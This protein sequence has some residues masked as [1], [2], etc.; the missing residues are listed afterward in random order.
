VETNLM[1][2]RRRD[3]WSKTLQE[4][5]SLHHDMRRPVAPRR[6]EPIGEPPVGHRLE[7][8]DCERGTCHIAT[9][10]LESPSI[11]GRHGHVGMQ[12]HPTVSHAARRDQ[13]ARLDPVVVLS[14]RLDSIPEP[15]PWLTGFKA[16][17]DSRSDGGGAEHRHQWIVGG[18][19][20][21][22]HR[23]PLPLKPPKDAP[24]RPCQDPAHVLG[25][26]CR[27]WSEGPWVRRRARVDPVEHERVE[28]GREIE[29]RTEALDESDRAALSPPNPEQ[30][31][32]AP[33]LIG[34]DRPQ[35]ATENLGG[36]LRTPGTAIA[37]RIRKREDPL[38]H[39]H[40]GK[41][42]VDE[43]SCAISHAASA[44]GRTEA[45]TFAR[46]GDQ[47]IVTASIAVDAKK[48]VSR[49]AALDVG[50]EL[51]FDEVGHGGAIAPGSGEEGLELIPDPLVKECLL[52]LVA[53]VLDGEASV[54]TGAKLRGE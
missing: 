20:I 23:D 29:C 17:G 25:L 46:E 14:D 13:C 1:S 3:E 40:F 50:A 35:E 9:Q 6:L 48:A 27:E 42:V 53:L 28:V 22:V 39:R 34:K 51:T 15:S 32:S 12:A 16:S 52:R 11:A 10:T 47:P 21:F 54:G 43:M 4:F 49:D 7:A 31:P 5:V 38:P 2:A 36:E 30:L 26:G 45:P 33:T 18:K 19:W 37:E 44:A 24:R 41:N 8:I